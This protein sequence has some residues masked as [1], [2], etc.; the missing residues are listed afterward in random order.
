MTGQTA[1]MELTVRNQSLVTAEVRVQPVDDGSGSVDRTPFAFDTLKE[2]IPPEAMHTFRITFSPTATGMYYCD[3]FD[4][5]TPGGNDL[6]VTCAGWG[7]GPRVSVDWLVWKLNRLDP[8]K[9][10]GSRSGVNWI[11]P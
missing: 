10:P 8:R 6:R 3:R 9:S 5:L 1:T 2:V 4:L 11:R 7:V